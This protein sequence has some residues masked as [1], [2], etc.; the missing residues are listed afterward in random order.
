MTAENTRRRLGLRPDRRRWQIGAIQLPGVSIPP[1]QQ[2]N[3]GE[4]VDTITVR[5]GNG[6]TLEIPV[7]AAFGPNGEPVDLIGD[8][9]PENCDHK[10]QTWSDCLDLRCARCGARLFM[11]GRFLA[12]RP[13][14]VI[15]T[16]H[17]L[18]V[19]AGWPSFR[20]GDAPHWSVKASQW[21]V[22]DLAE[23]A[24]V[25]G[26]AVR[27]DRL[28]SFAGELADAGQGAA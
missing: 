6:Q 13:A 8:V 28:D 21:T 2:S 15:E 20:G 14:E 23:F 17:A 16:M 5:A 10:G 25:G 19:R 1:G 11:P 7:A 27:R 9:T 24:H 4:P 22:I 3:K 12:N 18:W 26:L